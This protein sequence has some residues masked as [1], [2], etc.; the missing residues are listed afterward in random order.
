MRIDRLRSE[1]LS[2]ADR[3]RT[4]GIQRNEFVRGNNNTEGEE[5]GIEAV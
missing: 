5:G 3:T 4:D 1:K 2:R